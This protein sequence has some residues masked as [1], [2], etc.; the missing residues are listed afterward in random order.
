MTFLSEILLQKVKIIKSSSV[1][2]H[3]VASA[4][5]FLSGSN[6]PL[7]SL[8]KAG[9]SFPGFLGQGGQK[10]SLLP[11]G[12]MV[13]CSATWRPGKAPSR[14]KLPPVIAVKEATILILTSQIP[15][16]STVLELHTN[17]ITQNVFFWIYIL[18]FD[19]MFLRFIM[20]LYM[21]I[22]GLLSL[23][24]SIPFYEYITIYPFHC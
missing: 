24:C 2:G 15:S 17:I 11:L 23:L 20:P 6:F 8:I 21:L 13:S 5:L 18:F 7:T 22:I 9:W 10:F 16:Y 12:Q 4:P 19:I 3:G 14:W 1:L